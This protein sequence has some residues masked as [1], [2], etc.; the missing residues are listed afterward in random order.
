MERAERAAAVKDAVAALP[1]ELREAIVLF[2]YEQL[3]HEEIAAV[4]GA[5]TKAVETR[6]YRARGKL[7]ER[8]A[9]WITA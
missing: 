6:I 7:R 3:S 8:L 9:R 5:T 4:V 2:E 1:L